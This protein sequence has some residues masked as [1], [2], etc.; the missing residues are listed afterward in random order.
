M[1]YVNELTTAKGIYIKSVDIFNLKF[2]LKI[3]PLE[4]KRK[5]AAIILNI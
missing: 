5:S 3:T 1:Y 4:N 2:K